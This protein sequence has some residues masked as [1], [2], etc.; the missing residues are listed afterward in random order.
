MY[1]W[2]MTYNVQY[3]VVCLSWTCAQKLMDSHLK[4]AMFLWPVYQVFLQWQV[5][6]FIFIYTWLSA[7]HHKIRISSY[8]CFKFI[9]ICKCTKSS[10][11]ETWLQQFY[12]YFLWVSGI[13]WF[14]FLMLQESDLQI[15][16]V[17]VT[18]F[19]LQ[20]T[21]LCTVVWC[22]Q[23]TAWMHQCTCIMQLYILC[24]MHCS[25]IVMD[26]LHTSIFNNCLVPRVHVYSQW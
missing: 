3:C 25:D 5:L 21:V 7:L 13:W 1:D 6:Y 20:C 12:H 17:L 24:C 2:Q 10:F 22:W 14:C 23:L 15:W 19:S 26:S 9:C 18:L 16:T 4:S 11:Q 8:F